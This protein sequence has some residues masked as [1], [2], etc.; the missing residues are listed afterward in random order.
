MAIEELGP[1]TVWLDEPGAFAA[2]LPLALQ[3]GPPLRWNL[4]WGL[5]V[6]SLLGTAAI[7]PY[8]I[9]LMRQA[10]DSQITPALMPF[11]LV[12]S[13]VVE[14]VMSAGA[15]ALGIGLGRRS[16]LG[17]FLFDGVGSEVKPASTEEIPSPRPRLWKTLGLAT[18]LG[19]VLGGMVIAASFAVN[20]WMPESANKIVHP[21]A[22]ESFLAS[23][24]AG[25]R[26]EVW[27]RLG[28]MTLLA[29]LGM[30]TFR[31][32]PGNSGLIWT[33]N[34]LAALGFGAIHLPQAASLIGLNAAVV[35]FVF[36]GNGIPGIVFGWLFWRRGLVA[37]MTCHFVMDVVMKVIFPSLSR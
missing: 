29:W 12:V 36:V 17:P 4:F 6:I 3:S 16:G 27:L 37:A 34:V 5:L 9:S 20:P 32:E 19:I 24:G 23:I 35:L 28:L 10:K 15:I 31:R 21:P 25:I 1:D 18:G 7:L 13:L 2:P 14:G 33:A 22:W 26:E 8:S 30:V 11:I